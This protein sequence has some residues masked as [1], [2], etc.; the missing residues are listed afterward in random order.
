MTVVFGIASIVSR[1][2]SRGDDGGFFYGMIV[3]GALS[4]ILVVQI[5]PLG[6]FDGVRISPLMPARSTRP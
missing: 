1:S 2:C 5:A 6:F 3:V 4:L